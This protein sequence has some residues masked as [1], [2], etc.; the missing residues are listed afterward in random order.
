MKVN[1]LVLIG[2]G[3]DLAHGMPT[4][5][6]HFILDYLKQAA[7]TLLSY[8]TFPL[9]GQP[10][11]LTIR[12]GRNCHYYS[13]ES[14]DKYGLKEFCEYVG[15]PRINH[16]GVQRSIQSY[17]S[18]DFLEIIP[19]NPFIADLL[20]HCGKYSWV[21]IEALYYKHLKIIYEA[22]VPDKKPLLDN[23]N[24]S[25]AALS[26]ALRDYLSGLPVPRSQGKIESIIIRRFKSESALDF[27]KTPSSPI[28]KAT[29]PEIVLLN[30]NYTDTA[31]QYINND[32]GTAYKMSIINIHGSLTDKTTPLVFGFG[33]ETDDFYPKIEYEEEKG[34]LKNIKSFAYFKNSAYHK[35]IYFIE[36][37]PFEIFIFGHSCGLS[38]KTMLQL[39]FQHDNCHSIRVFYHQQENGSTNFNEVME[40]ISRQFSNKP[41]MRRRI[42]AEEFCEAFPQSKPTT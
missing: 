2:N 21:D 12:R 6:H 42:V 5:Y 15:E 24:S 20:D 28:V 27:Q 37:A 38:D 3:F 17:D 29:P 23:L 18:I 31:S 32:T 11:F 35:L 40:N 13:I 25:M 30:F 14:F 36:S 10:V 4:A 7:R 41:L 9:E 22:T 39:I 33:N 8:Y 26:E 34:Y 16:A 1:R 19:D